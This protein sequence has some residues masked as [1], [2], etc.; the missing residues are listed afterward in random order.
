MPPDQS[1]A[2][3]VIRLLEDVRDGV[4]GLRVDLDTVRVQVAEQK[5]EITRLRDGLTSAHQRVDRLEP[6][7]RLV[8][9]LVREPF[10][11][12]VVFLSM[13]MIALWQGFVKMENAERLYDKLQES[14]LIIGGARG[15]LNLSSPADGDPD[16]IYVP[17]E[18][19]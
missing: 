11:Q 6:Q 3:V 5:D 19:E 10:V 13:L 14:P 4:R 18:A 16:T 2:E 15:L 9:A 12:K 1:E 7:D 17:I 8:I